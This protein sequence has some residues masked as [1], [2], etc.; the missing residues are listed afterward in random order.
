MKT[1]KFFT[2]ILI[3]IISSVIVVSCGDD[4]DEPAS[5]SIVGTWVY[6]D[7]GGS[8]YDDYT[9]VFNKDHTGY[10]RNEY[11]S[12]ASAIEQMNFDWSLSTTSNG[13]NVLSVIYTSGDRNI[14]GP[15]EGG[16]AQ[17]NR[18]V[19]IA[20]STLSIELDNNYVMLFK[21]K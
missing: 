20:G 5:N 7:T 9:L 4:K 16:Y 6:S 11:G 13:S 19:T 14:D 18:Y 12:R 3:T 2:V 8:Y 1:F 17:Y 15:F 21:R 10:L